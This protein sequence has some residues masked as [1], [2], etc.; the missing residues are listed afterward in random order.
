MRHA[1]VTA[2]ALVA[3]W[4]CTSSE[5]LYFGEESGAGGAASSHG[6]TA[7]M[8]GFANTG[9]TG[10]RIASGGAASGGST[11]NATGGVQS[12]ATGGIASSDGGSAT[13][14]AV[15]ASV[16]DRA[17]VILY[18]ETNGSSSR[19]N[20]IFAKMFLENRSP[21]PLPLASVAVRYW[22]TAAGRS[23]NPVCDYA[24]GN[25]QGT[26]ERWVDQSEPSYV[27]ITFA[28]KSI[29][30]SDEL[31]VAEFQMRIDAGNDGAFDQ[32][33]DWSWEPAYGSRAPHDR[34]TVYLAQ[35][36]IWGCEPSGK[37]AFGNGSVGGAGGESG[38]AGAGGNGG[39][40][41]GGSTAGGSTAGGSAG[42]TSGGEAATGGEPPTSGGTTSAGAGGDGPRPSAGDGGQSAQP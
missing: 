36:L 35:K 1:L 20:Q 19:T 23:L 28:G 12:S 14:G 31:G 32:G 40:E 41:T 17:S 24:G 7:S 38:A 11:S 39:V 15:S 5:T 13:G 2:A 27:E 34:V 30:V 6:G 8:G 26:T 37:C 25:I 9:A 33:D 4:A 3:S 29:S 18:Y 10:G 21:D 22:M 16:L 42:A